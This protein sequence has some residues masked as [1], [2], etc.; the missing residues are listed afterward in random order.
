LRSGCAKAH[1][2]AVNKWPRR[3]EALCEDCKL[4]QPSFGMGE[5]GNK[6]RWCVGCAKAHAGAYAINRP[7]C[8]DCTTKT[9]TSF[10]KGDE[11]RSADQ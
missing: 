7:K 9:A 3:S 2:G 4:V 8:E 11:V 6:K 5:G 10:M 1:D